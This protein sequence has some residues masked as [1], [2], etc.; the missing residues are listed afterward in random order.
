MVSRRQKQEN[1]KKRTHP[2]QRPEQV[3]I[4]VLVHG[5]QDSVG[6]HHLHLQDL[7]SSH[8]IVPRNRTVP[9]VGNPAGDSDPRV[10]TSDDCDVAFCG[11]SIDVTEA[12]AG[13]DLERSRSPVGSSPGISDIEI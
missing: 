5:T 2:S 11:E 10:G 4:I 13:R 8:S 3:R 12:F 7:V 9:A 1:K 6:C